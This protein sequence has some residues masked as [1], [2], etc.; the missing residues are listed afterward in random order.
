MEH[1]ERRHPCCKHAVCPV[2][3]QIAII[4]IILI[5]LVMIKL[6]TSISSNRHEVS[7]N[8]FDASESWN[9]R[10]KFISARYQI[11]PV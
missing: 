11:P 9:L 6:G 4:I 10:Q 7:Y 1:L 3:G 5:I 2:A 8:A